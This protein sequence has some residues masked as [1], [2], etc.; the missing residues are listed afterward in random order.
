MPVTISKIPLWVKLLYTAFVA[1]FVPVY[2]MN[3]G[4]T[5]FIYFCDTSLLLGFIALWLESPLI[6]SMPAVGIVVVQILWCID[7]G[8]GFFG[9][10]FGLASYMFDSHTSLFLR[11][12]SLFHGWLPFVLLWMVHRLGYDRRALLCWTALGWTLLC[13]SYFLMPAPPAPASN[14]LLPVNINLVYGFSATAPQTWMPANE[15]F[16]ALGA[17]LTLVWVGT[18]FA[19]R[20]FMP[21]ANK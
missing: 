14:P 11:S 19:L 10:D 6:A 12:L 2:L 18:H 3:Y 17:A 7:F 15:W 20:R 5:N 9:F 8:L 1:V 21:A 4:P 16:L 13:V